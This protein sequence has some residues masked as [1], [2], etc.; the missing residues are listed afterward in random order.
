MKSAIKVLSTAI[1][2]FLLGCHETDRELRD[3][4]R[5]IA[6]FPDA[7]LSGPANHFKE[8]EELSRRIDSLGSQAERDACFEKW[9]EA[10]YGFDLTRIPFG[11][12]LR[13]G[14]CVQLMF[15]FAVSMMYG[16][17]A[18]S[19]TEEYDM[20]IRHLA[21][22]RRQIQLLSPSRT[23]PAGVKMT[24][25][26][27]GTG[28]WD[29]RREDYPK[30]RRYQSQMARYLRCAG[31]FDSSVEWC[32]R[33]LDTDD[34]DFDP[35][36]KAEVTAIRERLSAFLGRRLRTRKECDADTADGRQR[37]F[38]YLVPTPDGLV[39]CWT[40][41]EVERAKRRPGSSTA[42]TGGAGVRKAN[43]SASTESVDTVCP[44]P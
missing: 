3:I 17:R 9:A 34:Y 41:A 19:R 30:L 38:P 22:L 28:H 26:L 4:E 21:W 10:L 7:L 37:D 14:W 12:T 24:W 32:E 1:S 43:P 16:D 2:L 25:T 18:M 35:V 40:R 44:Q 33:T 11:E 36:A 15:D 13:F 6:G 29:V 5:E 42:E 27:G 23:Y 8:A 20:R 39:E 31:N